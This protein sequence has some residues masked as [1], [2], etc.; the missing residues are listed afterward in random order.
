MNSSWLRLHNLRVQRIYNKFSKCWLPF[1]YIRY[2]L[3]YGNENLYFV[4]F[5]YFDNIWYWN[6][7]WNSMVK[8][9]A[10]WVISQNALVFNIKLKTFIT[11]LASQTRLGQAFL[12]V[13][14]LNE[15]LDLFLLLCSLHYCPRYQGIC[16]FLGKV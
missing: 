11:F 7:I 14:I 16:T 5:F 9:W 15:P 13:E 12:F 3:A 2:H 8:S 1:K 4:A 6:I 10:Y